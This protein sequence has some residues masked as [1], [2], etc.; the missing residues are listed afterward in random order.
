MQEF[1]EL[2]DEMDVVFKRKGKRYRPTSDTIYTFDIEVS[3]IYKLD[4]E[5]QAFDYNRP[6]I[7]YSGIEK[8]AVP[9]IWM[10]G[11]ND[12]VYYGRHFMDFIK[13]LKAISDPVV[14]KVVWVHSLAYEFQF[15][16][17][18]L[19]DYTIESMVCR[20]ALKPISFIIKE[21]NIQFRCSYMLTNMSLD[22]ASKE[23]GTVYK[24]PKI[25][26]NLLR[27]ETT[28]LSK[29]EM[30]YC[31]YDCL[32]LRSVI[33]HYRN[34]WG[35]IVNIPLTS[36]SE[37]RIALRDRLD[38]WYFHNTTW[39]LV[40]D[41]AMFLRL[42]GTFAGGYTHSNIINTNIV[43]NNVTGYDLASSY[44]FSLCCERYPV[45][46][47]KEFTYDRYMQLKPR[48]SYAWFFEIRIH[49]LKPKY[50]NHYISFSKIYN[51]TGVIVT[52]NGRLVSCENG[53]FCLW[54][55]DVDLEIIEKSYDIGRLELIQIYGAYKDYIDRRIIRFTLDMYKNKTELKGVSGK[56]N[57]YKQSKA[58]INSLY[59]Q[60]HECYQCP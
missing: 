51:V 11:I 53:S 27:G 7:D 5:W 60:R 19:D 40:P 25:N 43:L 39:Q 23:Y 55:T 47:F 22:Q 6:Q 18:I 16:R 44:P 52:D 17:A 50:Y 34:K 57:L 58:Y 21:L 1:Q 15:L 24:Q 35:H 59:R 13:V 29:K 49:E 38:F 56:E 10:F 48:D 12:K 33:E 9:Y 37:V 31:E 2:K 42:M 8:C 28:K 46:P 26:Y 4:G 32:S 41:P 45:K 54:C 30:D 36:T 14:R 3:S 20:D